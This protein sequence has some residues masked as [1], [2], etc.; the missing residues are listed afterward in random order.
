MVLPINV[1][2]GDTG[3][4]ETHNEIARRVVNVLDYS[5]IQSAVDAAQPAGRVYFPYNP[6]GYRLV[7]RLNIVP[8]AGKTQTHV[9]LEM[10]DLAGIVWAGPDNE[11]II[12]AANWK[13]ANV[14]GVNIQIPATSTGIV[15]WDID[16]PGE[17]GS[18]GLITFDTCNVSMLG[19]N[20]IAWRG[21]VNGWRD[22]SFLTFLNCMAIGTDAMR[23]NIGWMPVNANCLNWV[24]TGGFG[25]HLAKA[26]ASPRP[27]N[28]F[29][30]GF[31]TSHNLVDFETHGA[32]V[33]TII[34]GRFEVGQRF[35]SQTGK[36]TDGSD[37]ALTITIIGAEIADY[38]PA[39]GA[40]MELH[41]TGQLTVENC[42]IYNSF[43][44]AYRWGAHMF[45]LG[46]GSQGYGTL[47][48]IGGSI[49]EADDP[50]YTVNYGKWSIRIEDVVKVDSVGH[51]VGRF[52]ERMP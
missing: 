30:Y 20:G 5:S 26:I 36:I 47:R 39:D 6:S 44:P 4:V 12:Y 32:G 19:Q 24:W 48:V 49:S 1:K 37:F 22:V 10:D 8:P 42:R 28:M 41:C 21:G 43:L 2:P 7:S 23:G 34:G 45:N 9:S 31:G 40:L 25:A 14:R 51:T 46:G 16:D 11:T 3:H 29:F 13:C 38:E 27:G 18:S 50:F 33:W 15:A 17:N 52:I 35:L